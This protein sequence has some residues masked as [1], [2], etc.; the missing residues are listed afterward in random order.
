[1]IYII[2]NPLPKFQRREEA[3]Y[4]LMSRERVKTHRSTICYL[5]TPLCL[6]DTQA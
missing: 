6:I 5:R 3:L 1:M 2:R 4:P